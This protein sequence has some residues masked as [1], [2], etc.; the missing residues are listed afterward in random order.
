MTESSM[1]PTERQLDFLWEEI[2]T[3]NGVLFVGAGISAGRF[4]HWQQLIDRLRDE[5][6]ISSLGGDAL[7]VPQWV[8]EAHGRATLERRMVEVFHD[9]PK[10]PTELQRLLAR[11]P[12]D[13][14]FTT[15]FDQLMEQALRAQAHQVNVVV[16]DGQVGRIRT[17]DRVT[18]VKMHGCVSAPDTIVVT[19]DDY[20]TYAQRHPAIVTYLQ[21]LLA[22]RTFLFVGFSLTDPNFR[23]IY[24]TIQHVLGAYRRFS[25]SPMLETGHNPHLWRYWYRKRLVL[26][27]LQDSDGVH[28][29]LESGLREVNG[30]VE[31]RT[32]LYTMLTAL[33]QA[34]GR[35]GQAVRQLAEGLTHLAQSVRLQDQSPDFGV[36]WDDYTTEERQRVYALHNFLT[37]M[38]RIGLTVPVT[39]WLRLGNTLYA[40][41]KWPLTVEAYRAARRDWDR[42]GGDTRERQVLRYAQ[43]NLARCYIALADHR[44][45]EEGIQLD[46]RLASGQAEYDWAESLLREIIL[47]SRGAEPVLDWEWLAVRPPDLEEHAYVTNRL[48][49]AAIA[50]GRLAQALRLLQRSISWQEEGVKPIYKTHLSGPPLAYAL[51]NLAK[52]Y[53]LLTEIRWTQGQFEAAE[54]SLAQA[55]AFCLQAVE[56]DAGLPFPYGHVCALLGQARRYP[57]ADQTAQRAI[58]RE[59]IEVHAAQPGTMLDVD[60]LRREW[61]EFWE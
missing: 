29:F 2:S 43:G 49:E 11:Y 30:R 54:E 17:D 59:R 56:A 18:L 6:G 38:A 37:L 1:Q 40:L 28:T 42:V 23:A 31:R 60:R 32:N 24:S 25:F 12:F 5:F 21:S 3:G 16:E 52:S 20:E 55:L 10:E 14:V 48:A 34:E 9:S 39:L 26:I 46:D 15:N 61:V 13:V 51:N 50:R 35:V 47:D 4:P 8:V 58:W 36:S 57:G 44:R 19:R 27:P 7:D 33:E 45:R 53:R 41:E 22:T